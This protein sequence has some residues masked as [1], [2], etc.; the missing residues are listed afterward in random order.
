MTG[1]PR[2]H[3]ND[4]VKAAADYAAK[5]RKRAARKAAQKTRNQRRIDSRPRSFPESY[6]LRCKLREAVQNN[7]PSDVVVA[8][9]DELE[10]QEQMEEYDREMRHEAKLDAQRNQMTQGL[11][12]RGG[13][14]ARGLYLTGA[15]E[16]MGL[17]VLGLPTVTISDAQQ[18]RERVGGIRVRPKGYGS[19]FQEQIPNW[20]QPEESE[21]QHLKKALAGYKPEEGDIWRPVL[22]CYRSRCRKLVVGIH[23]Q[24]IDKPALTARYHCDLHRPLSEFRGHENAKT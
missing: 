14:L 16:G 12:K 21:Y 7:L 19:R 23:P 8:L 13:M 10:R 4:A 6:F 22:H 18:G 5:K 20:E 15:P 17:L 9:V 2:K 1:R 11:L 24:D 3:A